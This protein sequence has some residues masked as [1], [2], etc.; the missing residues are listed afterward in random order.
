MKQI[1]YFKFL[2]QYPEFIGF[3]ESIPIKL[4]LLSEVK[5][6]YWFKKEGEIARLLPLNFHN[7]QTTFFCNHLRIK[8]RKADVAIIWTDD[9]NHIKYFSYNIKPNIYIMMEKEEM[10]NLKR[11]ILIKEMLLN[12]S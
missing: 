4:A 10:I 2:E 3:D 5:K 6:Q 9:E 12:K 7:K 1:N 11:E 8:Y